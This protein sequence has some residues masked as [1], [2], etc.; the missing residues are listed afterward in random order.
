MSYSCWENHN[1]KNVLLLTL[2]TFCKKGFAG[3]NPLQWCHIMFIHLAGLHTGGIFNITARKILPKVWKQFFSS[4]SLL[5]KV[6][7][8][9]LGPKIRDGGGG[10]PRRVGTLVLE[11]K[12]FV[13]LLASTIGKPYQFTLS[14]FNSNIFNFIQLFCIPW[15]FEID[16]FLTLFVLIRVITFSKHSI[17]FEN[18][19]L[20]YQVVDVTFLTF[21]TSNFNFVELSVINS[22]TRISLIGILY[23][24]RAKFCETHNQSGQQNLNFKIRVI[25]EFSRLYFTNFQGQSWRKINQ[26]CS[27]F[28]WKKLNDKNITHI[29]RL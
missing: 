28:P 14:Y 8:K 15:F 18:T 7:L 6:I 26:I 19:Y 11:G 20:L 21:F 4:K 10:L 2:N 9:K 3:N 27:S 22:M 23:K 25:Q 16:L 13:D 5:E 12:G 17:I 1:T 24:V 29:S